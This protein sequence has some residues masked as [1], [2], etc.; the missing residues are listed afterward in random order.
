MERRPE[1]RSEDVL[2]RASVELVLALADAQHCLETGAQRLDELLRHA[3]VVVAEVAARLGVTDERAVHIRREHRR[4]DLPGECTLLLRGH[5]LRVDADTRLA[6]DLSDD[7][8]E[9]RRWCDAHAND[10]ARLARDSRRERRRRRWR[11]RIH[12]PVPDDDSRTGHRSASSTR[13]RSRWRIDHFVVETRAASC[14]SV[15]SGAWVRAAA[16]P[17]NSDGRRARRPVRARARIAAVCS[18]AAATVRARFADSAFTAALVRPRT[19]RCT[20]RASN[21]SSVSVAPVKRT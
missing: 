8:D 14:E 6:E 20:R 13:R 21:R 10:A 16:A 2:G 11:Q 19:S 9:Q 4:R 12:L 17:R 18:R 5:V 1:L 3:L 15:A 7:W